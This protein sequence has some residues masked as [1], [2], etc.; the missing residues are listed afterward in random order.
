[1]KKIS[2]LLIV[3]LFI[4]AKTTFSQRNVS[5]N[6]Y[7]VYFTDKDDTPYDI[8]QPTKFLSQKAIDRR[9]KYNIEITTQDLPVN[10][11][12]VKQLRDIGF[13]IVEVSKWLNCAIVFSPDSNL[14][15]E[16]D[17]F[18]FVKKEF[19]TNTTEK[20]KTQQV[21]NE[22]IKLKKD[23]K[24]LKDVYKYGK[25][26]NQIKMLNGH[27]LHNKGYSGEGMTIAVLDAGFYH[28]NTLPVFKSLWANNQIFGWH[29]FVDG[30]TT[31]WDADTHGMM[32]L[33]I[34]AANISGEFVGTAPKANF[35]L[36]RTENA[37]SE[38]VIEEYNWVC[39][40]EFA[41]SVGVDIIHSSLGYFHFDDDQSY[42]YEDI[43][44]NTAISSIGSDI[45]SSKGILLVTSAGNTG[46]SPDK[47]IT[48]PADADSCL[49]I[50]ATWGG[51]KYIGF[52]SIGPSYDNRIKPN[53]SAQGAF[54]TVQTPDGD[55]G[56]SFGTSLSG[57]VVTG[58]VA[59]LWQAY[60]E[61]N[62]M[63]IIEAIQKSANKYSKPN[64]KLG[65]GVPDFEK[66]FLLLKK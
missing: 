10:P 59:C 3:S 32:V 56:K 53:V 15:Y 31:V 28:V 60:P 54:T 18:S 2:F 45:A 6:H 22:K 43:D 26:K 17:N 11:T 65:Y 39:A 61:L 29:D 51:G 7:C 64:V 14:I 25:G 42:T 63:E 44:G 33:S 58:L 57:P 47:H 24:K 1:M 55:Y 19:N 35:W 21:V 27:Y 41:D 49:A 34:I 16:L 12:Y 50:G 23:K 9:T 30:D 4:F 46:L 38:Y 66:A 48:A 8:N 5:P 37:D 62:N 13:E 36:I 52:S 40:A 20:K